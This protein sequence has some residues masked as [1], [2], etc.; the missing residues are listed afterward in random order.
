[1][2][3]VFLVGELGPAHRDLPP[4]LNLANRFNA[5]RHKVVLVLRD[6]MGA[7]FALRNQ[8]GYTVLQAPVWRGCKE[9]RADADLAGYGDFLGEIGLDDPDEVARVIGRWQT[10]IDNMNPALI[11][12]HNSPGVCLAAA[13]RVPVIAVGDGFTVP[14]A[15]VEAFPELIAGRQPR[16][17]QEELLANVNAVLAQHRAPRL[18]TLPS[19][20]FT[21]GRF[22]FV[23]P[24]LDPYRGWRTRP[25]RGPMDALPDAAPTPARPSA[26]VSLANEFHVADTVLT[27]LVERAISAKALL[28]GVSAAFL[29]GLSWNGVEILAKGPDPTR[30][31]AESSLV[32]HDGKVGLTTICTAVGRPQ[33]IFPAS[34]E[35]AVTAARAAEL[36]VA[37]V[38]HGDPTS[39]RI[40]GLIGETE[41]LADAA[42]TVAVRL[43]RHVVGDSARAAEDK[44]NRV[45]SVPA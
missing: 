4:L 32:V 36:G 1:M 9:K 15:G 39:E 27:A 25:A 38:V 3:T 11:I 30:A 23:L 24:D 45:L 5:R 35:N 2:A 41:K 19:L 10:V 43:D 6:V 21:A 28:R 33:L 18:R 16:H 13:G 42:R 17:D 8:D 7:T 31:V 37:I 26:Y 44:A 12:A 22:P 29:Q 20:F 14:P 34:A 40:A